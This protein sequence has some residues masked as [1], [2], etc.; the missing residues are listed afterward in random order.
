[1][2]ILSLHEIISV[3]VSFQC[4]GL[5]SLVVKSVKDELMLL[6]S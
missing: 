2:V 5:L 4:F 6:S 1:M 3:L